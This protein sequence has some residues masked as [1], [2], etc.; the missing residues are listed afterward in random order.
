MSLGIRRNLYHIMSGSKSGLQVIDD[1][2]D[3]FSAY[4]LFGSPATNNCL[5]RLFTY[6]G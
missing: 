4:I 5:L 3:V 1:H 6:P 2:A